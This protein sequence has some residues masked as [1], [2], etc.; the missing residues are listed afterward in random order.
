MKKFKK[1]KIKRVKKFYTVNMT[2][3]RKSVAHEKLKSKNIKHLEINQ[4]VNYNSYISIIKSLYEEYYSDFFIDTFGFPTIFD[5]VPNNIA[6]KKDVKFL[7]KPLTHSY[8]YFLLNSRVTPY[9]LRAYFPIKSS[10]Y[11]ELLYNTEDKDYYSSFKEYLEIYFN[12][13]YVSKVYNKN[14]IFSNQEE[15]DADFFWIDY[16]IEKVVRKYTKYTY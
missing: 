13:N 4:G 11:E 3:L 1:P 2:N 5:F 6:I 9:F 8:V 7:G 14:W 12:I 15:V 16:M 10:K